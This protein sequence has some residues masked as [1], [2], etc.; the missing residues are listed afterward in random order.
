MRSPMIGARSTQANPLAD[1]VKCAEMLIPLPAA[2]L[3][4]PKQL[5][6]VGFL[7]AR[8]KPASAVTRHT[9]FLEGIEF[10]LSRAVF[11]PSFPH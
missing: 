1:G 11:I 3:Q 4:Q 8:P 5:S 10:S 6:K 9:G 7:L 2:F